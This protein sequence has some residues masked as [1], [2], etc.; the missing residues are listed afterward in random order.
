L[1]VLT[2][3]SCRRREKRIVGEVEEPKI[4]SENMELDT[5]LDSIFCN[6]DQSGD[7][8]HHSYPMDIVDTEIFYEDESFVFQSVVFESESKKLIIEKRDVKN[9]KRKYRS[10]VDL[11]NMQLSQISG[12][13]RETRDALH[14]SIGVIEAEN[15]R[16]KDQIK[17]LEEALIPMPLLASPLA[18]AMPV[19]PYTPATKL[20]GS[21]SFLASCRGYVEKNIKKIMEL[22]TEA[23]ETS[24]IMDSLGRRAHNLLE[25]LQM[26]LKNE[27]TFYLDTVIPFSFHVNNMADTTRRQHDLPSKSQITQLEACWKEKVKNLYLIVQS[28][29]QAISKK[30]TLFTKLT[31]IDLAG[32]TNEFQ[33]PSLIVNSLALT[34]QAFDKQVDNFKAL[35][36]EIFYRILEYGE[37]H[38][39]NWLVRYSV[40]NRD[41]D[42]ALCNLSID[43]SELEKELFSI[44]SGMTSTSPP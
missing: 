10:E 38:V 34:K 8:I 3:F 40:Q 43:L 18:I 5:D 28:C 26:D 24:Q 9:K 7:A 33:D 37:D 12:L 22:I 14:D 41:I 13:H 2:S 32:R 25:L 17:E 20:K 36:L 42:Q 39:D 6:L 15:A 16:L 19:T 4:E 35:S 23:W 44:K 27:E 31:K 30:E 21:S 29:E 11:A 1:I